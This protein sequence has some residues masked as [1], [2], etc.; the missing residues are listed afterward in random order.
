MKPGA[1]RQPVVAGAPDRIRTYARP[2][3]QG[4]ELTLDRDRFYATY[5][6]IVMGFESRKGALAWVQVKN[7]DVLGGAVA[8]GALVLCDEDGK[9]TAFDA[10]SGAVRDQMDLGEPVK[11]CIVGADAYRPS[12]TPATAEPLAKQVAASVSSHEAQLAAGNRF[13]LGELA[14]LEDEYATK[15]LVDLA[16]DRRVPPVL[17]ADAR[18]LLGRR[19]Y[20]ARYMIEALGRHYDFI[21]D[22]A[23]PPPVGPMAHAL[24]AMNEK[25]AGPALA[26]HLMDPSD[27]DE[28]VKETAAALTTLAGPAQVPLLKQFFGMYRATAESDDIAVAVVSAGS[29]LLKVGGKDGRA[30]VDHAIGDAMTVP[31]AKDRLEAIVQEA[32][33]K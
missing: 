1:D 9:V 14:G 32:D 31:L 8:D 12:A 15:A 27:G 19:R 4:A 25:A 24:A 30:I 3:G 2:N 16:G 6:R 28:D 20:G 5:F 17:S 13:L 29:A 22:D 33:A 23:L 18:S 26:L 7:S 21:K 11:A 10:T